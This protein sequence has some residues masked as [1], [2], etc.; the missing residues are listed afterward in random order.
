MIFPQLS[1]QDGVNTAGE[2]ARRIIEDFHQ[3]AYD[4]NLKQS[5]PDLKIIKEAEGEYYKLK[6]N[7]TLVR[8]SVKDY[9]QNH[10]YVNNK[11]VYWSSLI[12]TDLKKTS[13]VKTSMFSFNVYASDVDVLNASDITINVND[14]KII[15][16]AIGS[17]TKNIEEIGWTCILN[18]KNKTKANN[19]KL[20]NDNLN[21]KI[22]QCQEESEKQSQSAKRALRISMAD[23]L[24]SINDPEFKD[25][26]SLIE[27][28]SATKIKEANKFVN[29]SLN[30]EADKYRD[31]PK[32]IADISVTSTG[33]LS[34]STDYND[35]RNEAVRFCGK[36]QELRN[37][38][39]ETYTN[40]NTM[41]SVR[42]EIK[43]QTGYES[44]PE[45]LPA[46]SA[47]GE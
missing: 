25:V 15:M 2:I 27:K 31:C 21:I 28:I 17:L 43:K 9:L 44:K 14:A 37:C 12:D 35:K 18:C 3:A 20:L 46:A 10:I 41:N 33:L 8:F 1:A 36:L 38:L 23:S 39:K 29:N 13:K 26:K 40:V 34:F 47:L 16:A 11:K 32:M 30:G 6:Y 45:R 24:Y 19:L 5:N 7:E 42:R 22:S 4:Y